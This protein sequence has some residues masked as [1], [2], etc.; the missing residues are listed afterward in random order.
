VDVLRLVLVVVKLVEV[1]RSEAE[2]LEV[3]EVLLPEAELSLCLRVEA[4]LRQNLIFRM[5][6]CKTA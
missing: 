5:F 3:L 2:V 4:N 1:F 6:T